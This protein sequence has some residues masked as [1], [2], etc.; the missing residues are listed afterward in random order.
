MKINQLN[1]VYFSP[2]GTTKK[3]L[4]T[5]SSKFEIKSISYDLTNYKSKDTVLQFKELDF[6]ILAVPVY[7]GRVPKTALD[8]LQHV[9]GNNTPAALVVT[10]GNRDY[11]DALL[12]LKTLAEAKGFKVI[13]AAAFVSE[14]SMA[15]SIGKGRPNKEDNRIISSF[16][17]QLNKK[18]AALSD[19]ESAAITVK[20]NSQY[21]K[22]K[23]TPVH[24]HGN[25]NCTGCLTCVKLC[26][27]G[28][29]SADSPKKTSGKKCIS[30]M[31][32]IRV[33]PHNARELHKLENW[34]T[35]KFITRKCKGIKQ[36]ELF[37]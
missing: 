32:C 4:K 31:R 3:V 23:S 17:L 22:Y 13:G 36:P 2:T 30:C 20:G 8:R 10:Y 35:K 12:E 6:V 21:R 9:K 15:R 29:I 34:I 33:C 24:P 27:A 19:L 18:L 28:A 26:P 11:D 1:L 5:I 16:G 14:H 25:E 7:S 37:L